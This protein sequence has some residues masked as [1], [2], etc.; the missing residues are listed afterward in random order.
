MP[1]FRHKKAIT[2]LKYYTL[3]TEEETCFLA[4]LLEKINK[5]E[6]K[7]PTIFRIHPKIYPKGNLLISQQLLKAI[8]KYDTFHFNI[9]YWWNYAALNMA[10]PQFNIITNAINHVQNV[11][12]IW[13]KKKTHFRVN[14]KSVLCW[15][16]TT[17]QPHSKSQ[18]SIV[19]LTL[20][21]IG[22]YQQVRSSTWQ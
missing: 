12:V 9:H 4:Q 22:K 19:D 18:Y 3:C 14:V 13:T 1:Q 16:S 20:W 15:L 21:Q 8:C 5:F 11:S 10:T 2:D 7:F 17:P 6:W